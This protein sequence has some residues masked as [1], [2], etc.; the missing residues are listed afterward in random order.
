MKEIP[1]LYRNTKIITSLFIIFG[2]IAMILDI[3]FELTRL[4]MIGYVIWILCN[5][6]LLIT[7]NIALSE[8]KST[9]G[10]YK[11]EK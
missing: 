9:K 10:D 11:F 6:S 1:R 2:F 3:K 4:G 5:I 7:N 8:W